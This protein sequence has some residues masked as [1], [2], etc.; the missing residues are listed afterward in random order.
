[1][2]SR[3]IETME[4]GGRNRSGSESWT[5]LTTV[6]GNNSSQSFWDSTEANTARFYR[7]R[8]EN[9]LLTILGD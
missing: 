5:L 3:K 2:C 9:E 8:V 6:Y 7:Y 1:M 4:N